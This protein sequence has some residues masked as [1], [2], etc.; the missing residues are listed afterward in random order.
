MTTKTSQLGT[1]KFFP[2]KNGTVLH[3]SARPN[4]TLTTTDVWSKGDALQ[5]P[6]IYLQDDNNVHYPSTPVTTTNLSEFL[7]ETRQRL[8][9][10]STTTA[11]SN[12][13]TYAFG[14][15][16][17]ISGYRNQIMALATLMMKANQEGHQQFLLDSLQ[18]KDTYGTNQFVPFEVYFD[19]DH[20]NTYYNATEYAIHEPNS[21][22]PSPHPVSLPRLVYY[23]P[24]IHH[25]WDR[26]TNGYIE[27]VWNGTIRE[28]T[29]P[30]GF[31]HP[32]TR[33][34]MT[35]QR[36]A[37]GKT[38]FVQTHG[39]D[40]Q[41]PAV[42]GRSTRNPAEIL[43]LQGALRPNPT[44]QLKLESLLLQ[45]KERTN[46]LNNTPT[47]NNSNWSYMTLHARV[48]PDMQRH[49]VCKDKKV[50]RLDE[51]IRMIEAKFPE[52]P[53]STVFMPINRQYLEKE[54]TMPDGSNIINRNDSTVNWIAVDNLRELNRIS[55]DGLWNGTV[56]VVEF[57]A[58]ALK[59]TVY[60]H[61][62][63]TAGAILN[64][65][66]TLQP[67]CRIF[68]GTEVSSFSHDVLASRF[69]RGYT[70]QKRA[71]YNTIKI[72]NICREA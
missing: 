6:A 25:Q 22:S 54:G 33:L 10:S 32:S 2:T 14:P 45:M 51:I 5:H 47:S 4:T 1:T 50:L 41:R 24:K 29:N 48:E 39:K 68:V 44:L 8:M 31:L 17:L 20:W 13:S 55:K 21:T 46:Q 36:Y 12:V 23:D 70:S 61:R 19:V 34:Q 3:S 43:M 58:N 18:H 28:P 38:K 71:D 53:V 63:S 64:F 7:I 65:F 59:G 11:W 60:E 62:P 16:H 49:P 40:I 72:S 27:A 69:Y 67:E 56:P 42:F 57:G 35:Y 37:R 9:E 26:T 30:Y 52:P 15:R 66:L